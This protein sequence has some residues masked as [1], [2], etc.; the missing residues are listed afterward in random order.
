MTHTNAR[1]VLVFRGVG[2]TY[3]V[4]FGRLSAALMEHKRA[5][6]LL[7]DRRANGDA[8]PTE[9]AVRV[10]RRIARDSRA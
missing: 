9:Q 5:A 7:A 1:T 8:W 10:P 2:A 3:R 6:M 4:Q